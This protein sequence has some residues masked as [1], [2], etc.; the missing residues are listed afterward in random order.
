MSTSSFCEEL[1]SAAGSQ[2]ERVTNHRFT[3]ELASATI[4]EAVLK[5]YLIQDHQFLDAFVCLLATL[6]AKARCLEDRI[7]GCQFLS[8]ITSKENTYF[9]HSFTAFGIT[10]DERQMTPNADCTK[11]FL[12]LM[13]D[14]TATGNLGEM[15]AVMVVCEWT[16]REWGERVLA[17]TVR[18]EES[19]T[20]FCTYEW[21]DLHSGPYF[22]SVVDYLKGLLDKEGRLLSSEEEG[23][24]G[25][26]QLSACKRR[27][28]EAVQCEEDFFDHAYA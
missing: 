14:V 4:D 28:L 24:D 16:Y 18:N 15:L 21:V 25:A 2:W 13:R 22:R 6:V 10:P 12:K 20:G 9:E 27:F 19:P 7:E 5:K 8:L 23:N 26:E 1:K 17:D 3:N 11:S